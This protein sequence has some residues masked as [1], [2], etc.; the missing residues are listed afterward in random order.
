M[1]SGSK[2]K[3]IR[4]R[5]L[6][7]A[8]PQPS[9]TYEETVCVA[10]ISD[11]GKEML[12]LYPVRFRNLPRDRQF[13]RFDLVELDTELPRDDYRPESRHVVEDSIRIIESGKALR[14]VTKVQ[15]WR[16]FIV[17]SLKALHDENKASRRSFG[18][19]RPDP[20]TVRFFVRRLADVNETDKS[21][22]Q[23][24]AQTLSLLEAPLPR[25]PPPGFAFGYKF[26]S[27]GRQH[28]HVIHDWEVQ[29][30][31]NAYQRKYGDRAVA[32]MEQEYGDRIPERN[33][34]FIMGTMKARPFVFI[35]IGLLRSPID[36]A[37]LSRQGGLFGA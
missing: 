27:G 24:L 15:L 22:S 12:R 13:D 16:P 36:P 19:V 37:D 35:I 30:A 21:M 17:P 34:H 23:N 18:I 29:A 33:L 6:V 28:E 9:K 20:G 5:V 31:Y 10:A 7:K 8:Y 26:K 14:D 32:M 2:Q 11:D 25:L 4:V 3:R 1:P